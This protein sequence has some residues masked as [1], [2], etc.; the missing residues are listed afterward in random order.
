MG[1]RIISGKSIKKDQGLKISAF[2]YF[3]DQEDTKLF[4]MRC[5]EN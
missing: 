1:C 2:R 3:L 5:C 4:D